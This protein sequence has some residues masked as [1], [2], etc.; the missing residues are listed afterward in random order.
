MVHSEVYPNKYVVSIAPFSTPACPDCSQN[1]QKTALFCMFSFLIFHPFFQGVSWPHLPLCADAHASARLQEP[2]NSMSI[3]DQYCMLSVMRPHLSCSAAW[4]KGTDN[5]GRGRL[6]AKNYLR[7]LQINNA[8]GHNQLTGLNMKGLTVVIRAVITI[9]R[10]SCRHSRQV[11]VDVYA[12]T[13]WSNKLSGLW[14]CGRCMPE[15]VPVSTH[16]PQRGI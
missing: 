3:G 9:R 16:T 5:G 15:R 12:A 13:F 2:V 8:T 6:N 1:I 7:R 10:S 11:T 4:N 14:H